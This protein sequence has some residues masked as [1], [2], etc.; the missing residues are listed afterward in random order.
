MAD[1]VAVICICDVS[2]KSLL[3]ATLSPYSCN[4]VIS[5]TATYLISYRQ[6]ITSLP[7]SFHTPVGQH[8]WLL[9]VPQSGKPNQKSR[10]VIVAL[11][12]VNEFRKDRKE[13]VVFKCFLKTY[14]ISQM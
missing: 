5:D 11:K 1:F 10:R 7:M 13:S 3:V 8:Y 14:E 2:E 9:N 6:L 12:L 4:D